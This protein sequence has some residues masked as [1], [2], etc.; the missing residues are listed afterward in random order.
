M[1]APNAMVLL[2]PWCNTIT[3][4]ERGMML[5]I[6]MN[7]PR[8]CADPKA[9]STAANSPAAMSRIPLAERYARECGS[10]PAGTPYPA[11]ANQVEALQ[12]PLLTQSGHSERS[13][14]DLDQVKLVAH[15]LSSTTVA[16]TSTG[17]SH[18]PAA[19]SPALA[20]PFLSLLHDGRSFCSHR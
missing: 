11:A 18:G 7:Q 15:E 14:F 9:I 10:V 12:C 8:A 16:C 5:A 20:S 17:G 4:S 1:D 3:A 6:S 2:P 13:D 19:E